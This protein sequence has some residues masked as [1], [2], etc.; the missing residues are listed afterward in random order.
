MF[1][2]RLFLAKLVIIIVITLFDIINS[3][4]LKRIFVCLYSTD[5][6]QFISLM[7]LYKIYIKYLTKIDKNLL[8]LSSLIASFS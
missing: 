8:I 3:K 6:F 7:K 4:L 5:S 1:H 2:F